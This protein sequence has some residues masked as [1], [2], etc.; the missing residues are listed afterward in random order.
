ML[1]DFDTAELRPESITE[2]ERVA[3]FMNDTEEGR[4]Q[5]RR[6]R[7]IREDACAT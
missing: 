6:V 1:F 7:L 3:K 4:Q 5:N 2:L